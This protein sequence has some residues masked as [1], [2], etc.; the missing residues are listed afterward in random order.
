ME[1]NHRE[2]DNQQLI[3]LAFHGNTDQARRRAIEELARR[4][5]A[6]G[7]L[8]SASRALLER[9]DNITTDAFSKGGEK[10]EREALRSAIKRLYQE[11]A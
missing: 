8:L 2:Q 11:G 9:L 5:E 1:I 10:L 7:D 6:A 3:V 4:A